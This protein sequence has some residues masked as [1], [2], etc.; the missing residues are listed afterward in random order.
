MRSTANRFTRNALI[1]QKISSVPHPCYSWAI[2]TKTTLESA[3]Y[4]P[5]TAI[6]IFFLRTGPRM[7]FNNET[8]LQ[9]LH[10]LVKQFNQ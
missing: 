1:Y 4:S 5:F 9:Y 10:N 7:V 2:L 6:G 8:T 3:R